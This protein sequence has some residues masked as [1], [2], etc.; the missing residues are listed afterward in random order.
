MN[1]IGILLRGKSIEKL[2]FISDNFKKCFIVNDWNKEI[3]I[4]ESLLKDK[5]ITQFSNSMGDPILL[6]SQYKRFEIS[7]VIFAF[8]KSMLEQRKAWILKKYRE[9]GILSFEFLDEKYKERTKQIRNTGVC[10]IFYAAEVLKAKNIW[11]AGLEFYKENYL[12]KPNY[13]HQRP[14]TEKIKLEESFI[15]IVEE[16]QMINFNL[17]TYYKGLPKLKNLHMIDYD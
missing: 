3:R 7:K 2:S 15:R 16:N 8:T 5:E 11:I 13:P 9:R 12:V 1:N 4:F 17:V 6:H 14:K 10:A